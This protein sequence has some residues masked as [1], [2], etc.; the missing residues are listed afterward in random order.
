MNE[1]TTLKERHRQEVA[2]F[3]M[4]FAFSNK[5]FEEG[6]AE[7]GLSP[8]DTEKIYRLPGTGGFYLRTD[9][10]RLVTLFDRHDQ[11]RQAAIDDDSTGDGYVYQMF[12]YELRDHEY[13]YTG[14][15]TDT[16]D[17]LDLTMEEIRNSKKLTSG[18][19]NAIK[20]IRK[21]ET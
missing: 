16:L 9:S 10:A 7:F 8:D 20:T 17:A 15:L 3:P 4:F 11:E 19:N 13:G 1:Y 2:D 14:S 21:E 18:L 12:L 6:M 5:Q